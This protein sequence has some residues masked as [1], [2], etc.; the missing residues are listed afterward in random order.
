M[1]FDLFFCGSFGG[2]FA[3]VVFYATKPF[4]TC[5][6]GGNRLLKRKRT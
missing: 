1:Q 4:S 5:T 6:S 3:L 2:S